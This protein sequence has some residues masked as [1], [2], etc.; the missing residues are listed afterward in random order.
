MLAKATSIAVMTM[1]RVDAAAR[2]PKDVAPLVGVVAA[3]ILVVVVVVVV[4]SSPD[5]EDETLADTVE[6]EEVP[7]SLF[8]TGRVGVL[9]VPRFSAVVVVALPAAWFSV[10]PL[11]PVVVDDGLFDIEA[12][13]AA[14]S[15]GVAVL[16]NV[17]SGPDNIT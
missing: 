11:P 7:V 8:R 5:E 12:S 13:A 14:T 4:S 16:C 3:S 9:L 17:L 15:P 6:V 1:I 10:L 2:C